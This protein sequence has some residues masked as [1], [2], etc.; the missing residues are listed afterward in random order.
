[1]EKDLYTIDEMADALR[2]K[3]SWIYAR[4]MQKGP[5]S[6]PRLKC[7]KYLRFNPDEVMAWLEAQQQKVD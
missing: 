2:V 4:T 6:I 3:P 5:G 1:M 7:G